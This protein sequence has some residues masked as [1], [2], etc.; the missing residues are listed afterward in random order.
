MLP[1]VEISTLEDNPQFAALYKRLTTNI[2][3]PDGSTKLSPKESI[4]QAQIEEVCLSFS[5]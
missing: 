4:S 2:L 3:N 5:C 1:P